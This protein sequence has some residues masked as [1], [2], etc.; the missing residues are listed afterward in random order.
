MSRE[1]KRLWLKF[2]SLFSVIRGYNILIIILAQYLASVFIMAYH[3]PV[4]QVLLDSNLF[5]IVISTALAIASG[6]L[7]NN[8]YDSEKDLINRPTKTLLDN[9][10]SQKTKLGVYFTLNF[11]SVI[12][13]SYVSFKAVL[14]FSLYI[15][16]LWLYSHKLK[17]YPFLGTLTAG[18]VAIL[19][20]FIIFVYYR[21]F[22][23]VIIVHAVFLFFIILIR[24]LVKDLEN[25]KGDFTLDYATIPVKYSVKFTKRL[26]SVLVISTIIPALILVLYFDSGYMD[27]YFMLCVVLLIIF[28]FQVWRSEQKIHYLVLHNLL[29]FV[30]VL[31]VFSIVLI[32]IEAV[33]RRLF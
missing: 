13:A 24:E 26:I 14:F 12:I 1:N 10:V 3:L 17:R 15:F 30:I 33:I 18:L 9:Y 16:I 20:F 4:K 7:I 2:L 25:L 32:D 31:G 23:S 22:E 5:L 28:L 29:K 27:Y 11:L 8:F 21:N 6:Y 19:P